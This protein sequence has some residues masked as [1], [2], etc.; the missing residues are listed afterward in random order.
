MLKKGKIVVFFVWVLVVV[1]MYGMF[2]LGFNF[3]IGDVFVFEYRIYYLKNF[4]RYFIVFGYLVLF[5]IMF[6][7]G[8]MIWCM[9]CNYRRRLLIFYLYLK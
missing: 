1:Y 3:D 6:I 9:V 7:F 5:F 4:G 8:V 2:I